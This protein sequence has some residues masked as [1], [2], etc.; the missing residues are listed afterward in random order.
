MGGRRWESRACGCGPGEPL[1]PPPTSTDMQVF[2]KERQTG[3]PGLRGGALLRQHLPPG[4]IKK[5]SQARGSR[6]TVIIILC[7]LLSELQVLLLTLPALLEGKG[8]GWWQMGDRSR[9]LP[10]A[11][12]APGLQCQAV[13]GSRLQ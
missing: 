11:S 8:R 6:K 4:Q 3:G 7:H 5:Y 1:C 10:V 12:V 13:S 9:V 2:I